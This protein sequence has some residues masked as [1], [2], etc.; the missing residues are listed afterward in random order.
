MGRFQFLGSSLT[1]GGVPPSPPI[2]QETNPGKAD[3]SVVEDLLLYSNSHRLN[4]KTE[5]QSPFYLFEYFTK[6]LYMFRPTYEQIFRCLKLDTEV[7]EHMYVY[8]RIYTYIYIQ[9]NFFH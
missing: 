3:Y 8:V 4:T 6:V 1:K 7:S 9:G 2:W 5:F